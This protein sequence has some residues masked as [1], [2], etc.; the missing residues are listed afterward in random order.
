M[1][2]WSLTHLEACFDKMNGYM[3]FKSQITLLRHFSLLE[4][5]NATVMIAMR[6][7]G[8]MCLN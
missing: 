6:I 2:V 1:H 7:L 4:N 3:L 8:K 5:E